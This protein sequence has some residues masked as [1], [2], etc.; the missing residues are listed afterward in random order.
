MPCIFISHWDPQILWLVLP[1]GYQKE[2]ILP[3]FTGLTSQVGRERDLQVAGPVAASKAEPL[4]WRQGMTL[5]GKRKCPSTLHGS[6]S[7]S[8]Y[9]IDTRQIN[10]RK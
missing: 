1:V 9:E 10:K 8:N 4:P 3:E 7:W 6:F 5:W 2:E